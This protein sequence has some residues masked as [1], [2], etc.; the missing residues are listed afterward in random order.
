MKT[1][2]F[3]SDTHFSHNKEFLYEPRGFSTIEEM[4]EQIVQN[5][6]EIVQPSDIVYHLGDIALTDTT[7]AIPYIKR[8]NGHIIWILGNH[9]TTSKIEQ[10]IAHCHNIQLVGALNTSYSTVIKDGKWRFYLSHYPVKFGN[11]DEI[12]EKKNWCLCGHMH[13]Q[14]K[15][16]DMKDKCYHVELDAHAC[17][18]ISLEEIK[19]DLKN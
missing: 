19:S 18:P 13:T 8:L 7:A 12:K 14:D 5:W 1:L 2:F 11:F 9:D 3:T 16:S 15:F 4:N 10:I 6:N 17:Y